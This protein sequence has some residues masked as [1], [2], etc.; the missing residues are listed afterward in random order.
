MLSK[1][2]MEKANAAQAIIEAK[3]AKAEAMERLAEV[4]AEIKEVEAQLEKAKRNAKFED[5][6]KDNPYWQIAKK[7]YIETGDPSSIE[8]FRARQEALETSVKDRALKREV[9]LAIKNKQA[10][11]DE[12]EAI[13]EIRLREE[14]VANAKRAGDE[15]LQRQAEVYLDFAIK[16]YKNLTGKDWNEVS[17]KKANKPS[18]ETTVEND[19]NKPSSKTTVENEGQGNEP[20]WKSNPLASESGAKNAKEFGD[21]LM[22]FSDANDKNGLNR[23]AD[24]ATKNAVISWIEANKDKWSEMGLD[25]TKV[26]SINNHWSK[27]KYDKKSKEKKDKIINLKLAYNEALKANDEN[28]KERLWDEL[29]KLNV[30]MPKDTNTPFDIQ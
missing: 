15:E 10:I 23:F 8:N 13:K 19:V 28:E 30:K 16:N 1:Y 25:Q 12:A 5:K 2:R 9:E 17:K 4:R 24:E 14:D 26:N 6:Y 21:Y 18:S 29:E 22:K 3:E 7:R 20:W 27:E 11:Y